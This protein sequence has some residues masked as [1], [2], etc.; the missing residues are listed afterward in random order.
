VKPLAAFAPLVLLALACTLPPYNEDLSLAQMSAVDMDLVTTVGPFQFWPGDFADK[1]LYFYPSKDALNERRFVD[2]TFPLRGFVLAIG[3]HSARLIVVNHNGSEY[4]TSGDRSMDLDNSDPQRFSF[5]AQTVKDGDA[6]DAAERLGIALF[7][8]DPSV[9][10]YFNLNQD[11]NLVPGPDPIDMNAGFAAILG[12]PGAEL[13]GVGFAAANDPLVDLMYGLARNPAAGTFG[14]AVVGTDPASGLNPLGAVRAP[15]EFAL[16]GLPESLENAFYHYCAGNMRSY[17]S[18][19]DPERREYRNFWWDDNLQLHV[20]TDPERR[21]DL[22][23]SNGWLF[24]RG[25]N[26]GYLYDADGRYLN[27][28]ALGGLDLVY[29][30]YLGGEPYVVFTMEAWASGGRHENP[31]LYFLVYILPTS[32]LADL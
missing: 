17:L 26:L 18:W 16:P 1:E 32:K 29:E 31:K 21:I 23:L 19:Y 25:E 24:S 3:E 12:W 14:E 11:F 27:Q 15:A 2:N 5:L 13:V 8:P 6:L 7:R 28:F 30:I 9:R 10:P 4:Y 20:M 22:V